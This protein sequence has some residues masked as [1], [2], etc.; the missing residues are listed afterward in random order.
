MADDLIS[1]RQPRDHMMLA[2]NLSRYALVYHLAE[3]ILQ[4]AVVQSYRSRGCLISE[5][6]QQLDPDELTVIPAY[7][8]DQ[9]APPL[10]PLKIAPSS[11]P[12]TFHTSSSLHSSATQPS[13][14]PPAAKV[15]F[16]PRNR[17]KPN[18]VWA[19]TTSRIQ[20]LL[21][22]FQAGFVETA[23]PSPTSFQSPRIRCPDS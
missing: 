17:G 21:L 2:L 11:L 16:V 10:P 5:L 23:S 8:P 6:L 13:T 1:G 20:G 18:L 15:E 4:G 3:Y 22:P 12:F 7:I 9:S 14:T 19:G